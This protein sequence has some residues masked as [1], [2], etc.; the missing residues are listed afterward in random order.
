MF[1]LQKRITNGFLEKIRMVHLSSRIN[2]RISLPFKSIW[3]NSLDS[4]ISDPETEYSVIFF[5]HFC[6]VNKGLFSKLNKKRE[7]YKVKYYLFLIDPLDDAPFTWDYI[8]GL[9]LDTIFTYNKKDAD[10]YGWVY[11]ALPFSMIDGPC[12]DVQ[13]DIYF[14]GNYRGGGRLELLHNV[15]K[16]LK[17]NDIS[18]V[19]RIGS[20]PTEKQKFQD[21]I[22]YN[23]II[24][25]SEIVKE[26]KRSNCILEVV[27]ESLDGATGRYYE[28]VCYN[29][30][31]LTTNKNVVNLP[32]YNPEYMHVF[33]KPEDIDWNWVKERIPVDYHYD[34]RFSPTHFIDELVEM[35]EGNTEAIK[36]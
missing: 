18:S 26:T 20:V 14:A 36:Q 21:G 16:M 10:Q 1:E 28:A 13:Y 27:R 31:L 7:E 2:R 33:E 15:Y 6:P 35:E 8:K 29:K 25:Y 19:Y 4:V 5:S 30:K 9:K 17:E 24:R 23:Q 12:E 32:F 34:G 22:I 11:H 3:L